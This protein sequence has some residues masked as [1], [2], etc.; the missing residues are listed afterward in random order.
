MILDSVLRR[1]RR[2]SR[3]AEQVLKKSFII[4]RKD[5]VAHVDRIKKLK[6]KLTTEEIVFL[7]QFEKE[8]SKAEEVIVKEIKD[9]SKS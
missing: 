5:I 8:L 6:R 4:L 3:E 9:I 7:E 2:E 1:L